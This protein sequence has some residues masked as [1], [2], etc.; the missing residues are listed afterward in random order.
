MERIKKILLVM[1]IL[2]MVITVPCYDDTSQLM[3]VAAK[4]SGKRTIV[5]DPGHGGFDGGAQS[6]SGVP[7]K[8][9]NLSIAKELEKLLKKKGFRVRM[10]R[11]SD[12]ALGHTE[13]ST[14]RSRKTADLNER[15]KIIDEESPLLTVSIHLNSFKE[16]RSVRG[17]QVFYP[18]EDTDKKT[19]SRALAESV[20]K[21]LIKGLDDGTERS[22]LP[23]NDI[24]LMKDIKTP[25]IIIECGFLSNYEEAKLLVK[26]D[27]QKKTA[28]CIY[29]GIVKFVKLK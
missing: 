17:A 22:V 24:R 7:E 16:D 13:S 14:I 15:K 5:I 23:K 3:E 21:E 11:E 29:K 18:E 27:Y 6:E 4:M 8:D 25:I 20:Q 19:G 10:T 26:E 12:T 1:L 9:I 2:G 28:L